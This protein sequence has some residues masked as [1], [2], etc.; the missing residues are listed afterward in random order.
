MKLVWTLLGLVVFAYAAYAGILAFRDYAKVASVVGSALEHQSTDRWTDRVGAVR[1]A[2][3]RDTRGEGI[4][5]EDKDV[6]VT[7]ADRLLRV[8]VGW[9]HAMLV[10]RGEVVLALPI[11]LERTAP[12]AE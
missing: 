4:P 9:S 12:A 7:E 2:V 10:V 3:I 8:R 11:W 5:V 6:V 1:E